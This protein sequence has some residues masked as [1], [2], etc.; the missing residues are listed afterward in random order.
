MTLLNR[1]TLL[2]SFSLLLLLS[3]ATTTISENR[4]NE[5]ILQ[6][7]TKRHGMTEPTT[8]FPNFQIE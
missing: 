5:W 2:A 7:S 3:A 8:I 4:L 1:A 6:K